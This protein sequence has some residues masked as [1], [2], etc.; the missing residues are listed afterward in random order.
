MPTCSLVRYSHEVFS[1]LAQFKCRFHCVN[2]Y[3]ALGHRF[4]S[5]LVVIYSIKSSLVRVQT[6]VSN[7]FLCFQLRIFLVFFCYSLQ[8]RTVLYRTVSRS[9]VFICDILLHLYRLAKLFLSLTVLF[10]AVYVYLSL[11][12][13]SVTLFLEF[14]ASFSDCYV[15]EMLQIY[16][17]LVSSYILFYLLCQDALIKLASIFVIVFQFEPAQGIRHTVFGIDL[18][19]SLQHVG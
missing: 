1:R 17:K 5:T 18:R 14:C 15:S 10:V 7:L 19:L 12:S 8:F 6:K 2:I 13:Y 16:G 3:S 9:V 4:L 11:V